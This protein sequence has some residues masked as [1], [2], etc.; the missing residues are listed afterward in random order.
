MTL[1]KAAFVGADAVRLS[2][3]G[4]VAIQGGAE[5]SVA[6]GERIMAVKLALGPDFVHPWH[7]HPENESIG[8]VLQGR[9]EMRIGDRLI[10]LGPG[11]LWHHPAGVYHSTRALEPTLAVEC[12]APPRADLARL[13]EEAKGRDRGG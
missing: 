13:A 3:A 11:D 2:G 8:V 10:E 5:I 6:V 12:H 1:T 4:G 7:N 9:L